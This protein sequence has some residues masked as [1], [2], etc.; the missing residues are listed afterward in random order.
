MSYPNSVTGRTNREVSRDSRSDMDIV[1]DEWDELNVIISEIPNNIIGVVTDGD[2]LIFLITE[3]G[4][5][6]QI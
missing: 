5:L 1:F 4:K 2:K 6:I 3:D